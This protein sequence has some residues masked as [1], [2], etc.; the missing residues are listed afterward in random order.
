MS[1]RSSSEKES[2][3]YADK[4]NI[5]VADSTGKYSSRNTFYFIF[6]ALFLY[7]ALAVLQFAVKSRLVSNSRDFRLPSAGI[8][9]VN[10]Y[11]PVAHESNGFS[12]T[13]FWRKY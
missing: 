12:H 3:S 11:F 7:G 6:K 8:K 13:K 4:R 5:C 2:L 10:H 1:G 9:S